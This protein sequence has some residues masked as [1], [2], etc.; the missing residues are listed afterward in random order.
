MSKSKR[1]RITIYTDGGCQPN[2]GP[3]GWGALLISP[4]GK[5]RELSG[6]NEDTT[7]NQMELMAAISAL[8]SLDKPHHISLYTDSSYV[9][10]GME[11]WIG[12]WIRRGWKT[13]SGDPVKNRDLWRRLYATTQIHHIDWYW[14]RGHSGDQHNEYVDRLA[15]AARAKLTGETA[16]EP[17][18][19]V[20]PA[21]I[22]I[23]VVSS[24]QRTGQSRWSAVIVDEDG[25]HEHSGLSDGNSDNHIILQAAVHALEQMTEPATF[26][27]HTSNEY[28]VKGMSY[29]IKGWLKK[30]WKTAS[31]SPVK[32]RELWE[33]LN[34]LAAP[35]Q[36]T[37]RYG[38]GAGDA[39]FIRAQEITRGVE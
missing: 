33:Q 37:W 13:S 36:I 8:E 17:G 15:T 3:G 26:E 11:E 7:N 22:R 31:G 2:P 4:D 1:P 18:A 32:Y 39:N 16:P 23:Y 14:V 19:E 9:K 21:A 38:T 5:R 20:V 24:Y 10:K 34:E 6:A 25:V 28:L 30:D 29:W 27:V 35:H 12:G